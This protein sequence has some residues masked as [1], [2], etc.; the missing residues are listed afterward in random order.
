MSKSEARKFRQRRSSKTAIVFLHGFSGDAEK[1]WQGFPQFLLVDPR[2]KGWDVW[3]V[4]FPTSLYPELRGLWTADPGIALL[5]TELHTRCVCGDLVQY[6]RLVLIAHSMGGLV[7]QRAIVDS[8]DLAQ[9]I[10]SLFL[11]G[12]PSLGLV[13]ARIFRLLKLQVR[14]MT[15]DGPFITDLRRRWSAAFPGHSEPFPLHAIAGNRDE[16]VPPSSSLEAFPRASHFCVPGGHT[17]LV[18]PESVD[19]ECVKLVVGGISRDALGTNPWS[20]DQAAIERGEFH[21]AIKRLRPRA[22]ELTDDALVDLALALDATGERKSAIAVLEDRRALGTDAL[23]V[24]AGRY[25][26]MW[27]LDGVAHDVERSYELYSRALKTSHA[28]DDSAQ[29]FYHSINLAF[30]ELAHFRRRGACKVFAK[31]A[32]EACYLSEPKDFWNHATQGEARLY[33]GDLDGAIE[34]YDAALRYAPTPR[35]IESIQTQAM[36]AAERAL[37]ERSAALTRVFEQSGTRGT[38]GGQ[39]TR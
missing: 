17:S 30:L 12:V 2:L 6:V 32:L 16:F 33:L 1:T 7:A 8:T 13:K 37:G 24:L 27:L 25:K 35:Q 20:N 39:P 4:G 5:A 15:R 11:F 10:D 19:S 3:S 28:S 36:I 21:A 29:V 23:G 9:R 18:K 34:A 14:D 38:G 26:R 31:E 22:R